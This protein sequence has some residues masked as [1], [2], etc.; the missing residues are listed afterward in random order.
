MTRPPGLPC[1]VCGRPASGGGPAPCPTCGLPAVG[2]AALVVARIG[3]TIDELTR[4]RDRLLATLRTAAPGPAPTAPPAPARTPP[5][6]AYA[7][8]PAAPVPAAPPPAAPG[9]PAGAPAWL[10]APAW[11]QAGVAGPPPPARR[12]SPQQVLLGLGALA[13][14]AGALAF[15]AVAWNRLGVAGQAGVLLAVTAGLCG[16]SAVT[17]RRGLRATEEALAG[18]GAALLAVDLG[19]AYALGLGGVDDVPLRLWTAWSCAAVALVALALGRLTR[20]TAAWPL[21]ALLTAQPVP[22]LLLP[23][24]SVEGPAGVA[25]LL[26]LALADVLALTAVRPLLRPVAR[27]LAGLAAAGAALLG[28][29]VAWER[30]AVPAWTATGLLLLAT[31]VASLLP[32]SPRP[33]AEL[34]G[35]VPLLGVGAGVTAAAATGSSDALGPGGLVLAT[36]LGL[37]LLAVA[38]LVARHRVALAGTAAG[39]AVLALTGAG[40]LLA[41]DRS[42]ALAPLALAAAAPAVLTAVRLPALRPPAVGAALAAPAV[43]VLLAAVDG[44]LDRPAAGLLLALTAA[45]AFAVASLRAGRPEEQVAAAAGAVVG[46]LAVGTAA[47]T[48]ALGQVA[49][50]LAVVGAAAGGYGLVARSRVVQAAAVAALVAA[51]WSAVAGAGVEVVEAYTLPA[52]AGLAVL[53][54]PALRSGAGSWSAEAPAVAVALVPSALAAVAEP[55]PLRWLLVVVAAALAASGGA[56]A[57][58]QATFVLGAGSLAW[59][60][61]GRLAPYAPLL[62]RWITLGAVGVVLLVVGA[63]YERRRQQAREAVAWVAQMR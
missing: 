6:R 11:E 49:V 58:R 21:V 34:P 22:L 42:A 3:A 61:L 57:H 52:A 17:A 60:V 31:V 24:D 8:P 29:A 35:A 14:V 54:V 1:P 19:A 13:L 5:P 4:D 40:A 26:G 18:A 45:V 48:G 46:V 47:S 33:A 10:A 41:A 23:G 16:A 51:C 55:S 62:P 39:G 15:V 7:P 27:L 37:V 25:A 36:G 2:E 30:A 44:P 56:F 9:A 53:A 20:S 12:L 32:R 59:V 50:Q 63:T 28:L 43:A 38:V